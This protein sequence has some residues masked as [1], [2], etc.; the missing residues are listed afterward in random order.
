MVSL[1]NLVGLDIKLDENKCSLS[2]ENGVTKREPAI[3][4]IEQMKEVL[5]D[6][7][8]SQ[9]EE[10]Y[11][12]YR[13][14]FCLKDD[15]VIKKNKLRF[16]ITIIKPAILGNEFMKT[17][18]HYHPKDY[19]ELYEVVYGEAICLQQRYYENDFRK[20]KEVVAVKARQGQKIVC[21]PYFGHILI[22]TGN[23]PLVT[24]NWVSA[25]F[26]SEYELY[27]KSKGAVYYAL[28]KDKEVSWQKN[29]FYTEIPQIKF[30]T[31]NDQMKEF[32]LKTGKPM[33]SLVEDLGKIDFL[34]HPDKYKYDNVFKK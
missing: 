15:A 11:Y 8:V 30:V 1:N 22:N 18:G 7:S 34:N 5:A 16:D 31:P 14:V 23:K 6:D 12:M 26:S 25:E 29:N 28:S 17:A 21:L 2:F 32:G 27:K 4:T 24:A 20:I 9:P 13:D 19:P 3:R 33:Y 10:L